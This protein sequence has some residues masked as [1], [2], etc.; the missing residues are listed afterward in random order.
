M[1]P[2]S[3]LP[4]GLAR[5]RLHEVLDFALLHSAQLTQMQPHWQEPCGNGI[6]WLDKVVTETALL[7]LIA[8]RAS[9]PDPALA[10]KA[11]TLAARIEPLARSPAYLQKIMRNPQYVIV[12]GI[13]HLA[14]T[15]AGHPDAYYDFVVRRAVHA[16]LHQAAERIPFRDLDAMWLLHGYAPEAFDISFEAVAYGSILSA[17]ASPFYLTRTDG[18]AITHTVFYLTD[19][20]RQPLPAAIHRP[21]LRQLLEETI[22]W[23]LL[24]GDLDLLGELLLCAWQLDRA[25]G[26]YARLG[27]DYFFTS[28]RELGQ[29]VA[30]SFEP[31]HF[32][33]L[34][35]PEREAYQFLHTYHTYYVGALLC[36]ALCESDFAYDLPIGPALPSSAGSAEQELQ[37]LAAE[38]FATNIFLMP[39]VQA[40]AV[41]TAAKANC[42]LDML[43]IE[44]VREYDLRLLA[45]LYELVLRHELAPTPLLRGS[46]DYLAL[47]QLPDGQCGIFAIGADTP[48]TR[49]ASAWLAACTSQLQAYCASFEPALN[50][51]LADS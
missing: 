2:P 29:L 32:A 22:A 31:T 48:T 8:P 39:V 49:A 17:E 26:P 19:F 50:S 21:R 14:L 18:Y 33:T 40:A 43:L 37:E 1:Q 28:W 45:R 15:A 16:R 7:C 11:Q 42:L 47:Q 3:I 4:R 24:A 13:A 44:A 5:Q 46:L 10:A 41:P 25:F 23:N 27:L 35:G 6:E 30:P 38:T 9:G 51:C 12:Y 34:A 20:G 36:T